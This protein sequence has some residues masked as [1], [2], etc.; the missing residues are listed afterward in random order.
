MTPLRPSHVV[1]Y[2]GIV[3][4]SVAL[5]ATVGYLRI[6][7]EMLSANDFFLEVESKEMLPR[8]E[9][10]TAGA[11]PAEVDQALREHAEDDALVFYFQVLSSGGEILFRSHNLR[12]NALPVRTG[13]P[14]KLTARVPG[15]GLMRVAE[16]ATPAGHLQV[17]MSLQNFQRVNE[18]FF[19]IMLGGLPLIALLSIALGL[20]LRQSTLKP[21]RLMQ[22]AAGHINASN[23]SE[24]IPVPSGDRELAGLAR[25]LNQMFDRLDSSFRQIKRFTADTS[26]ELMTP[27]S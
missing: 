16:Y 13:N 12:T 3:T 1:Y 22:A 10:L 14:P 7:H 4:L 23:L 17:A 5:A 6:R 8:I 20:R 15:L 21:V 19:L 24:R 9:H 26:H 11:T 25:L 18:R 2:A 27:L